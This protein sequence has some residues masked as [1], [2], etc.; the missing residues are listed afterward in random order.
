MDS[1]GV[2]RAWDA[3]DVLGGASEGFGETPLP[4]MEEGAEMVGKAQVF[5]SLTYRGARISEP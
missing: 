4:G 5:R 2:D 1:V 3:G